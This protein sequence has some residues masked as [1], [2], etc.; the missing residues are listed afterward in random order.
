MGIKLLN[1]FLKRKFP[2]CITNKHWKC[3]SGKKIAVDTNNYIYKFLSEDGLQS[4]FVR[5]C[6][7]FRYYDITPLFIFD[8]KP[9]NIKIEEINQRKETRVKAKIL[10]EKIKETIDKKTKIE[11]KRKIVK[12][13]KKETDLV[14][15]IIETFGMKYMDSPE[16]SDILCCKLAKNKKVYACLSED[17]DMLSYGCPVV[18]RNYSNKNFI[19]KYCLKNILNE[20]HITLETFKYLTILANLTKENIFYYFK[21]IMDFDNN[22]TFGLFL[23]NNN[24]ITED[25]Y[26]FIENKYKLFDLDKTDI[27]SKCSYILINKRKPDFPKMFSLIEKQ[28]VQLYFYP[29]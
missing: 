11:L 4:G 24:L 28:P 8:G 2:R 1:T 23:Y 26:I 17:M 18:I 3:F 10:F 20:M 7:L 16:E 5:M 19:S 15:S 25:Q 27:L 12:V 6:E 14:K 22:T 29:I 13:T 9:T 21:K